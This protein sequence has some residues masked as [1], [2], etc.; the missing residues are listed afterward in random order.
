MPARVAALYDVHGNL[1]ALEAVLD[2]VGREQVDAI[3]IGGDAVAGPFPVEAFE[4]LVSLPGALFVRGNAD[5]LVVERVAGFGSAWC[6]D[7]L[8]AERL[9]VVDAWPFSRRL[10]VDGLG[11]VVFCHATLRSDEE[12]VTQIT[13][14]DEVVAAFPGGGTVV[15]GHVH[16]QFDRRY[17]GLRLVNAGS[18]GMPYEG[19]RGAFWA[20]LGRG[21]VELRRAEYDV[22]AA[23]A[24]ILGSDWSEAGQLAEWLTQPQDPTEVTEVFE[25]RRGA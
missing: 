4:L 7:Q 22:D 5:R 9:A 24:A 13:P 2:D 19:R 8:G 25:A 21:K 16:V 6:A 14:D 18:V 23:A 3:V 17:D 1:P 12:I 15:V 10:A 11:E 20:L